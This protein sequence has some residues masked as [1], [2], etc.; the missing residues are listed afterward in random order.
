MDKKEEE[1]KKEKEKE[2]KDTFLLGH[3]WS[4][5]ISRVLSLPV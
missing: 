5:N 1:R 2:E 3:W 4:R